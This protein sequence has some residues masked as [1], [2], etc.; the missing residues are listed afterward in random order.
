M[1]WELSL[2]YQTI[3]SLCTTHS[4]FLTGLNFSSGILNPDNGRYSGSEA[5]GKKY[6]AN[7]NSKNKIKNLNKH[8]IL[9][10]I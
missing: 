10:T 8:G 7:N 5:Y 1:K 2:I 9:E 6:A 3:I 4:Q